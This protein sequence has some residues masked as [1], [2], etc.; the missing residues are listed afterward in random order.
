MAPAYTHDIHRGT[1]PFPRSLPEFQRLF[2]DDA[3]CASYLERCR[4]PEMFRC[5]TCGVGG[6]PFRFAARP[7]VL[8]CRACRK[9]TSLTAGTVMHR[10]HSPLSTWFWGAYLVSGGPIGRRGRLTIAETQA[11]LGVERYATA[12]EIM[13][14]LRDVATPGPRGWRKFRTLL[15]VDFAA[16]KTGPKEAPLAERFFSRVNTSGPVPAHCPELGECHVWTGAVYG[17]YGYGVL[18]VEA[19]TQ[20]AHRVAF[21]LADGHWPE[22]ALHRCDNPRCVRRSHLF[23]GD[24]TINAADK[25]AKGRQ[26][27]KLD[28]AGIQTVLALKSDG[29]TQTEI[30]KQLGVSNSLV[31]SIVRRLHVA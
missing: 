7:G 11:L 14:T 12:Q 16:R 24:R 13:A 21:F 15:G 28:D 26:P 31:S 27:R 30:A 19:R 22:C 18:T 4:W 29:V 9:D 3:A 10:T 2:P 1:L 17:R 8:R 6:D 23:E 20:L 5:P 25:I